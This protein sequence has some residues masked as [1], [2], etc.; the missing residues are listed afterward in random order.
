MKNEVFPD[1]DWQTLA[2]EARRFATA[3]FEA[4]HWP[5]PVDHS[6]AGCKVCLAAQGCSILAE[7]ARAEAAEGSVPLSA[8]PENEQ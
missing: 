3:A 2:L 6:V 5:N 8:P 4:G 1:G 7:A